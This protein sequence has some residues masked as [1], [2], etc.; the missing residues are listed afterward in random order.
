MKIKTKE[1]LQTI[2]TFE[3]TG[4]VVKN[5]RRRFSEL[6]KEADGTNSGAYESESDYAGEKLLEKEKCLGR[7]AAYGASRTGKWG[8]KETKKLIASG[9]AQKTAKNTKKTAMS[10]KTAAKTTAKGMKAVIKTAVSAVKAAAVG[11]KSLAAAVIAG[12]WV[13]VLIVV[14]SCL[15]AAI[16]GSVYAIFVPAGNEGIT[17]YDVMSELER[18]YK[19]RQT[20]LTESC[21]YDIVNYEG[22]PADWKEVIAVYAVK[23][24]LDGENP[25]EIATFDERKA[26]ELKNVYRSMNTVR[27]ETE[28]QTSYVTKIEFDENG[29]PVQVEEEVN[30]VV[31]TVLTES[32]SAE[33]FA[34]MFGFR[35]EQKEMLSELLSE[36]NA[37]LWEALL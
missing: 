24:N 26:D 3:R 16:A 33:E 21:E 1:S 30:L 20:E 13:A 7:S 36:K 15:A 25:Q 12:G 29:K 19:D 14:V 23:L 8:V 2:K 5:G 17:I 35:T 34:D 37:E 6:N 32:M 10:T 28:I 11:I 18:E 31:L 9:V 4:G 22:E 27:T